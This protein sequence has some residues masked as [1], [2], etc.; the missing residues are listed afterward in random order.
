M[1]QTLCPAIL[2]SCLLLAS[3]PSGAQSGYKPAQVF[4]IPGSA[5]WDYLTVDESSNKLYVTHWT[6]VD[7]RNKF[8]GDPIAVI[9]NTTGVHGVA[10]APAFGKGY[11]SNGQL[12]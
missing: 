11:T 5:D 6:S 8:T 7:I 3:H 10:L 4:H 1:Q 12:N 2:L 9:P